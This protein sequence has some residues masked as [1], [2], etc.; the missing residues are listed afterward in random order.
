[1]IKNIV[2]AVFGLVCF[3]GCAAGNETPS[4]SEF[5][6]VPAEARPWV[7]YWWLKGNVTKE[8]ITRDIEEMRQKG[9]GGILL[10]DSRGY[11]D[12]SD[13]RHH[14][15]VPLKIKHEFMSPEWREMVR[16]VINEAA[17]R[18]LK[19][20]INIANAGG[21][22]R[23]VWDMKEDGPKELV[24]SAYPVS[25]PGGGNKI[26]LELP[27]PEGKP[28]YQDIAVLGI[29]LTSR[30]TGTFQK[31][32][33]VDETSPAVM[34]VI[35]LSDS[36]K[37]RRLEWS[38]PEGDWQV[39][40]FGCE[41][42]GDFGSVDILSAEACTRYFHL[43]GSELI[44]DAG[45]HAGKTLTH[46]YNV[47]WEGSGPNWTGGFDRIFLAR[48]GYE[49][50][51]Y[52]PVLAGM[53]VENKEVSKRF[54]HDYYK[55]VAH[56]FQKNCYANI[57]RLCH[58][59]G[60][61]WHSENG[62]PWGRHQPMFR[63]ADMLSF[64][65]E[66]DIAQGEFWVREAN[67][68]TRSNVRYVSMAAHIYGQR[69]VAVEAFTHMNRHWTMYPGRL[70]PAADVNFID[71]GN[72]FIWHT[73]TASPP[74]LGK[75]GYEYFA[76]THINTNVTWWDYAA[77]FMDYLGRCQYLLRQGLFA[78]DACVYV[79]DKNYT[80]WGRG[81]KWNSDSPLL[82]PAGYAC[83]LL[84][85]EALVR[86]LA[87]RD[88]KLVL[89]DGMSY[90]FLVLDPLEDT[91]PAEALK[92][93]VQLASEGATIILGKKRPIRAAG[94]KNYPSR[95]QEV[96]GLARRLWG[97]QASENQSSKSR[98]TETGYDK[99]SRRPLGRGTVVSG[100][101][102][103]QFLHEEQI[104]PDFSGPF[105]YHHRRLGD[106]DVYFVSGSGN[107]DCI[108][109]VSGRKPRLWDPVAGKITAP[110][111]YSF[112]LDGR[113]KVALNLAARGSVF[114]VFEG[115]PDENHVVAIAGDENGLEAGEQSTWTQWKSGSH[116][117]KTASGKQ[118]EWSAALPP[119]IRLQKS[120]E[121]RF[122]PAWG[123]R[124]KVIFDQLTLWNEHP[125][126][127]IRYYSGTAIYRNTFWLDEKQTGIPTRLSIGAVHHVARVKVNGRELGIVWT[128]PY[129]MDIG[130][131]CRSGENIVEMEVANCWAN[132]LIG[133]AGLP[134]GQRLTRTN[135]HLVPE[136]KTGGRTY[137]LHQ[138]F[139]AE[140]SLLPSGLLGPVLI[141]FGKT[142][143]LPQ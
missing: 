104:A 108:F 25:R 96:A 140:D 135:L 88:G 86:R 83:D 20:S 133:D 43:I 75:P 114:V 3:N 91:L 113:T 41:T 137:K 61:S 136:R 6:R 97:L 46:F 106:K 111:A 52:L 8:Q 124:G 121:V 78:A 47:S 98:A 54:L 129:C 127:A 142:Q 53:I 85:T 9:I 66:N 119:A 120:W 93:I 10:F 28:Y 13:S 55:T 109:R 29:R 38:V 19:V 57:G 130:P 92:K 116:R 84:D 60:M 5:S 80:A 26:G 107:A 68:D 79:S 49:L 67:H 141:E 16:H 51:H 74:E 42:I 73:F 14:L 126:P 89:P 2:F 82:L 30:R 112:T 110:L 143:E 58:E 70:K 1:M 138:G 128:A 102:L 63:E 64:L 122:D 33:P 65:G 40:R 95:D 50:K 32:L 77:P 62:G 72:K 81:E 31:V 23:G 139:S 99:I 69:E 24:W 34:D 94:L 103:Q 21:H 44:K 125:E 36:V 117:L 90:R 18:G 118:A 131:A 22:L 37:N 4:A 123:K 11:Y 17:R 7:Y 39:L 48:N 100:I 59:N 71:G 35:D 56:C 76:G 15:P 87:C 27:A 45:E 105:E 132:R 101:S 115:E 12:D 134:P